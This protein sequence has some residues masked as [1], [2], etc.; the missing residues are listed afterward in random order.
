[1]SIG[2]TLWRIL[3]IAVVAGIVAAIGVTLYFGLWDGSEWRAWTGFGEY[4]PPNGEYQR[5]KTLWDWLDLLVVPAVLAFG[6]WLLNKAH[7]DRQSA[8]AAKQAE[9]AMALALDQH[10]QTTFETYLDQMTKLLL[11]HSLKERDTRWFS[12]ARARTLTVM[13]NLDDQRK[14]YI[15]RFLYESDLITNSSNPLNLQNADAGG[16]HLVWAN[17]EGVDLKGCHLPTAQLMWAHLE[18][19]NLVST[20]LINAN[21]RGAYLQDAN[22]FKANLASANLSKANLENAMLADAHLEGADLLNARLKGANLL[23]TRYNHS[24]QW[25]AG[26]DV[27]ATGAINVDIEKDKAEFY[28][29]T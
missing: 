20:L 10:R 7:A 5:A 11:A 2:K 1:M 19:A 26:F 25:P 22:L 23:G 29:G 28:P 16:V 4:Q 6:A 13:R 21:L 17:L 24:T 18:G 12:I 15:I 9:A 3:R 14:G 27:G 8:V